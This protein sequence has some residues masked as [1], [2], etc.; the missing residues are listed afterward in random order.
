MEIM[1]SPGEKKS[2]KV[3]VSMSFPVEKYKEELKDEA[4]ELQLGFFREKSDS[5]PRTVEIMSGLSEI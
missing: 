4:D 5:E 1:F 2:V 3:D